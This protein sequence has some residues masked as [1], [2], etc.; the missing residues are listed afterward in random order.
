[1]SLCR[2]VVS[3]SITVSQILGHDLLQNLMQPQSGCAKRAYESQKIRKWNDL[4]CA[5]M[6]ME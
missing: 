6:V 4:G 5:C 1:M 3:S 2:S